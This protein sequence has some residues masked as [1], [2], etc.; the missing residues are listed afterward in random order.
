L[1]CTGPSGA[2]LR[3][4]PARHVVYHSG[5]RIAKPILLVST[6]VGVIG[7]LVEGYRM[8]GGLV[9]IMFAMLAVISVAIASVVSMARREQAA[10]RSRRRASDAREVF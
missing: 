6:P 10:L 1:I 2:D 3:L 7:G 8:A 4:P 5:V 9:F